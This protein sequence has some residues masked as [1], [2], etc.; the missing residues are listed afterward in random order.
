MK[1]RNKSCRHCLFTKNALGDKD[2]ILEYRDAVCQ[3]ANKNP[4]QCH[5][6]TERVV[7]AGLYA[8][9]PE[10]I[11]NPEKIFYNGDKKSF[12]S[13]LPRQEMDKYEYC[14]VVRISNEK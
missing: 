13:N 2:M 9:F 4:F 3:N 11:Q 8:R 1:I 7:C 14:P 5:E 12:F 6:H 10:V